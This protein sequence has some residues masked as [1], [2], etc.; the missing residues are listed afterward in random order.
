VDIHEYD[1][2]LRAHKREKLAEDDPHLRAE[3]RADLAKGRFILRQ[4]HGREL[5]GELPSAREI[6][7]GVRRHLEETLRLVRVHLGRVKLSGVYMPLDAHFNSA[8]GRDRVDRPETYRLYVGFE[9]PFVITTDEGRFR[10]EVLVDR[11]EGCWRCRSRHFTAE[12]IRQQ[13]LRPRRR[14]VQVV[15]ADQ[16]TADAVA[17]AVR[18]K[19]IGVRVLRQSDLDRETDWQFMGA[20]H[21]PGA[22][23]PLSKTAARRFARICMQAVTPLETG[24]NRG[25]THDD[26]VDSGRPPRPHRHR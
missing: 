22:F 16:E 11:H 7:G 23:R 21:T 10:D 24:K 9:A 19:A 4:R 6:R 13:L 1:L 20:I 18:P 8:L 12:S 25:R 3:W 5:V 2:L 15:V 14:I 17:R 26:P